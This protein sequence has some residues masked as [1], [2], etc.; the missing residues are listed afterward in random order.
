VQ[1]RSRKFQ[2]VSVWDPDTNVAEE[3][4]VRSRSGGYI[5]WI[6]CPVRRS[7]TFQYRTTGKVGDGL[8]VLGRPNAK[9]IC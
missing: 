2:G 7:Y 1:L 5:V 6:M 8:I 3:V 4:L 9:A